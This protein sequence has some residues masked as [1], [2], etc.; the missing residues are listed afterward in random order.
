MSNSE[1]TTFLENI[2]YDFFSTRKLR[3]KLF[4]TAKVPLRSLLSFSTLKLGKIR[5]TNWWQHQINLLYC[6][7]LVVCFICTLHTSFSS[8]NGFSSSV[9]FKFELVWSCWFWLR[10]FLLSTSASSS[11]FWIWPFFPSLT[12]AVP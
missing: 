6:T 10:P 8:R 1:S 9:F 3:K 2:Y 11:S 4:W 7:K 12:V 5:E